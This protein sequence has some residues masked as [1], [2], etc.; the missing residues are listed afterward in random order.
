MRRAAHN[1]SDQTLL[2]GKHD[3]DWQGGGL[4]RRTYGGSAQALASVGQ[5]PPEQ[6]R[7]LRPEAVRRRGNG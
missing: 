5:P 4:L 2:H 1:D 7:R 6:P 3:G